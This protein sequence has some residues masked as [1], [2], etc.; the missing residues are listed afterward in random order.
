[1]RES[2]FVALISLLR[3][4]INP[5]VVILLFAS[6]ISLALGDSVGGLIII[7]MVLLSVLPN[8]IMESQAQHAVEEIRKQVATT[9]AVVRDGRP[10]EMPVADLVL[11]DVIHLNAGDLVPADARL[12]SVKDLQVRESA[13]TGESLCV[14]KT[15]GDLPPGKHGVADA[16]NCV[17]MGTAVQTGIGT[18]VIACTGRN[19]AFGEIAQR[20]ATRPP[21]TE[22]GRG[23]RHFG[24]M[25][26]RVIMLLVLFVL[27]VNIAFHRP[28]LR[29]S[30]PWRLRWG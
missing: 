19:T 28:I 29:S 2:R 3:F 4:L 1:M 14:E 6:S 15:C 25:I 12:L 20:L 13:L 10:Q 7:S 16:S 30:S 9:A 22:F 17:F 27:L 23:I 24:M 8:F 5:L 26:T 18:A 11:G 21:E